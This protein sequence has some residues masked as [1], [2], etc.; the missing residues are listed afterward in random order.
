MSDH[1]SNGAPPAC[2]T[3]RVVDALR[4]AGLL[5]STCGTLPEQFSDLVD[6]S[7]RVRAG[8]AFVAVQGA[9]QDGHAWIAAAVHA[10]ASLVLAEYADRLPSLPDAFPVL[11]VRDGRRAAAVAAAA[12]HNW[13]SRELTI[14]GVTGT[15]GKTTTVG[16]LRHMLHRA[17]APAASI[18]TLGVILG[19]AVQAMPGGSGL[20]TPGPVE[21]QRLLR[22]LR[23][24]GVRTVAMEVSSHSLEQRRVEGL[25]FAVV[26]FTNL[27]RDHLDYHGTME[28]YRAAKLRLL[29]ALAHDGTAIFNNDDPAWKSVPAPPH[30]LTFGVDSPADVTARDVT[31]HPLGANFLLVAPAGAIRVALPLIGDFNVSNALAAASTAI[32]LGHALMDV[33]ERLANAPQVPGR[34]ERIWS[35]PTVLRDYAHTP[36]ALDRALRAVRPFTHTQPSDDADIPRHES[37]LI[38]VFGCGGD[39]DR[40]KRPVMGEIAETLADVAIVTSDNPRT[41]DPERILDDIEVGMTRRR[42]IRIVD[43]YDA[44]GQA[45][46]LAAATDVIVLAGK[47]HETYQIRGT[48]SFP[49]DEREIVHN[50]MTVTPWQSI[51]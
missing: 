17:D 40:G 47:G 8:A 13:P 10:G 48:E 16:L 18:G 7:R 26:V 24:V 35:A 37:Q 22:Q 9:D 33:A 36:D 28:H 39:R 32:A 38:V 5:D 23:D 3:I 45:L 11:L 42:H 34:L 25:T 43:R 20:T 51:P 19:D 49:F 27:T 50:L 14:V 31:F 2:P 6:D 44:I 15:N 4:D 12:F 46:R 29:H 30:H 1:I 41:E 21:L